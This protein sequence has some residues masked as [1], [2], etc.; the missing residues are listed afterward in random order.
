MA[1]ESAL[2]LHCLFCF[3]LPSDVCQKLHQS[4]SLKG[5]DGPL[6]WVMD[7][8]LTG[9]R[10]MEGKERQQLME[11][12]EHNEPAGEG[13]P[14][15][16]SFGKEWN[17]LDLTSQ[18]GTERISSW[19]FLSLHI[20]LSCPCLHPGWLHTKTR[21]KKLGWCPLY[22]PG[23][24]GTEQGADEQRINWGAMENIQQKV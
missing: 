24:W 17:Q 23:S 14:T 5:R 18:E 3:Y 13:W 22:R 19:T 1:K 6:K 10:E 21:V 2:V 15:T 12:R 11:L 4:R 16:M 9:F 8:S 20:F 7:E